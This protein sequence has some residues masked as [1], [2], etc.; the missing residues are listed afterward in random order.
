MLSLTGDVV[1]FA[2]VTLIIYRSLPS[3]ILSPDPVSTYA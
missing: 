1:V 3:G 2:V